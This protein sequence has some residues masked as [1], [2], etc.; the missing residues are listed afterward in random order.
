[1]N[2]FRHFSL[3]PGIKITPNSASEEKCGHNNPKP[4]VVVPVVGIVVVAV[5]AT[6]VVC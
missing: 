3:R 2:K 5:G 1:M 6:H 4:D